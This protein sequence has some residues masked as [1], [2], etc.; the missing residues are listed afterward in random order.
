MKKFFYSILMALTLS[1]S[2][3]ATEGY[4][5]PANIRDGNILHCFNWNFVDIRSELPNIAKAGFRAIQIS[6]VQGNAEFNAEWYYAYMPYDFVFKANGNGSADQLQLLCAEADKYGIAIIAD[7]VANHVNPTVGY[8][9]PWW[10]SNGRERD[11]GPID[12]SSRY[13]ITHNNLGNYKDVN[14]ELSEV[15]QRCKTFIQSLKAL[16]VKG[17]RWDAAKHIGLPSES[18]AFWSTVCNVAGIEYHYGEMLDGP[19]GNASALLAEYTNFMDVTDTDYSRTVRN[20]FK[21]NTTPTALG[22]WVINKGLNVDK[23]VYWAESHDNYSNTNRES[24]DIP[25]AKIDRAYAFMA[26]RKGAKALYLSRPPGTTYKTIKMNVKGSTHFT[27]PEVAAV[28]HFHNAMGDSEEYVVRSSDVIA[29][30]RKT[31]GAVIVVGS[32]AKSVSI[33]NPSSY[34]TAGTY[35]DEVSGNKFTVTSSTISGQVNSTG[36]AV[37]Y[38][39]DLWPHPEEGGDYPD[40][41]YLV[42]QPSEWKEP[43]QANATHYANWK[44]NQSSTGVYEGSFD[45][46]SDQSMF[47]FYSALTGWDGGDSFGAQLNDA[48]VSVTMTNNEYS[49]TIVRGKGSYQITNWQGGKMYITVD[50]KNLTVLFSDKAGV[51]PVTPDEQEVSVVYYTLQGVRTENPAAGQVAIRVATMASGEIRAKK[52]LK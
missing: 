47:R 40:Q 49:G 48:P 5:L 17:I 50:L 4:G 42:G 33:A 43:T 19:G 37:L 31:G 34:L 14:S 2:A 15:Q 39:E 12:Y 35:T 21:N 28:N 26:A 3:S 32:G 25:Q 29:V 36:I 45:I 22:D 46:A 27:S 9:D 10:N 52:V 1:L 13:S 38:S 23:V 20:A 8:R 18:C 30:G 44:L 41:I 11:N 16:G 51:E 7:V 6:P 24:T